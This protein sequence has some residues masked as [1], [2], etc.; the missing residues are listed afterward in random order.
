MKKGMLFFLG[1][2]VVFAVFAA[3]TTDSFAYNRYIDG[4]DGCHGAFRSG[5]TSTKPGNTWPT[6]KHDVHRNQMLAGVCEAC[7]TGTPNSGSTFTGSSDGNGSLPGLGCIGCHGNDYGGIV[8]VSGAGLRKHHAGKGVTVCASCHTGDPTPLP[9]SNNP[10]YYGKAGVNITNALNTDGKENYTS[11]G[12]GLDNDGDLLYDQLAGPPPASFDVTKPA[13]GESVPTG[14]PY[15]V[16]WTAADGAASYKVKVSI[17]GGVTWS[18]LATSVNDTTTS[19]DVPNTIKKNISNAIIKVIAYDSSGGK[20]GA[21][22]SGT[23]SVDVLTITAPAAAEVVPQNAP[24]TITWTANGTAVPPD[25]LVVKYTLNNG[26]TWKTAQGTPNLGASSFSWN[27]PAVS[28]TK[29]KARVKVVLKAAG[30]TVAKAV[31]AK[32]TVQ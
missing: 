8:G 27:V 1:V 9:E 29:T 19:W 26:R 30:V 21:K 4:C 11:D 5:T 15:A 17:D 14:A 25:Q 10:P 16:T 18:T 31:T 3:W 7:H 22:K 20:L 28:K 23:F 13:A 6:N 24:Y 12:L 2:L 32:F